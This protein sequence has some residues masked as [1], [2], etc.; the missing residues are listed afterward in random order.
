MKQTATDYFYD[1]MLKLFMQYHEED[2]PTINFGE[3]ITEAFDQAKAMEKEQIIDAYAN[4]SNDR[5]KNTINDFFNE[6][7]GSNHFVDTNEMIDHI[8]DANKMVEISEDQAIEMV[9]DMNKQPMRFHCVP[10]EIS[11]EELF[12]QAILA[13]EEW[14]GS[15]CDSEIDAY[16][17]GAKWMQKQLKGGNQ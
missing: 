9:K 8:V 3:V 4:G 12:Q 2:I 15:G 10:K 17:R 16:F 11:D 1:R 6:T 5:L 7:Y 13:M 14:Y